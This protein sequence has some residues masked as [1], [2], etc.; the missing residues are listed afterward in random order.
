M[1]S[2]VLKFGLISGFILVGAFAITLPLVLNGTIDMSKGQLVGYSV[3]VVS[4]IPVFLGVRAYRE[5]HGGA[6]TF[7]RAFKV[8][9]LIA[10]VSSA[11]YVAAW[12]VV[13]FGGFLPGFEEKMQA[14][15]MEKMR[16]SG[17]TAEEM[18]KAQAQAAKL[19]EWYRNPLINVAITFLEPL[20]VALIMS[21]VTAGILR[22]K[23]D[24][25]A[26]PAVAI[27]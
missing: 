22:K 24:G 10:L 8:G 23:P 15:Q 19:W 5:Q 18:A 17:A 9:F 13:Y 12:Q 25:G 2:I 14:A 21:L 27:A 4:F 20:P 3:M 26:A 16:E 6:I 11:C 1:R 7:G